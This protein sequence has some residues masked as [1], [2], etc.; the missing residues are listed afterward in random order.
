MSAFLFLAIGIAVGAAAAAVVGRLRIRRQEPRRPD[1]NRIAFPF[2]GTSLTERALEA[3]L[4]VAKSEEATLV[5]VYLAIVPMH[6]DM[7]AALPRQA[8]VATAL[9]ETIDQAAS[10]AGV[11]V[12]TRIERGRTVRHALGEMCEHETY[13]RLV[14]AAA[15]RE[16]D[17]LEPTDIA[18]VLRWMPGEILALRPADKPIADML[19]VLT[20]GARFQSALQRPYARLVPQAVG[21]H[22]GE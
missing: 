7:N 11:P 4:R 5:P 21:S 9:L 19:P 2:V 17:G 15:T 10:R 1:S 20:R 22:R 12:E 14:V 6:L 8:L 3:A 16:H 13:D 18:W